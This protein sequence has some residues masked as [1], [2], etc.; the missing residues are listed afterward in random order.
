MANLAVNLL[1]LAPRGGEALLLCHNIRHSDWL[2]PALLPWLVPALLA[3]LVPALLLGHAVTHLSRLV[4]ALLTWLVPALAV[5]IAHLLGDGGALL[6]HDCGAHLFDGGA[7]LPRNCCHTD[8]LQCG[9][10]LSP[11]LGPGD[12][13]LDRLTLGG[14][15]VPALLLPDRLADGSDENAGQGR[16]NEAQSEDDDLHD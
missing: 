10:A 15:L 14:R 16:A 7:A 8:L 3:R 6:L 12:G 1:A 9:A 5:C 2:F 4:P 13:H 11:R